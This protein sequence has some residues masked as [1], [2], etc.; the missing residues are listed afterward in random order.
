MPNFP[1]MQRIGHLG[2][3][4]TN[5]I[6]LYA[7]QIEDPLIIEVRTEITLGRRGGNGGIQPGVDL[8]AYGAYERGVS[9]VHAC[10]RRTEEGLVLTDEGSSNGTWVNGTLLPAHLSKLLTPG[11][12]F[13]L[14]RLRLEVYFVPSVDEPADL[15][16]T[17]G[18]YSTSS[19][20]ANFSEWIK[21]R[22]EHDG[23]ALNGARSE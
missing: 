22:S 1:V 17:I 3:L 2:K 5:S 14:G 13:W 7:N 16:E 9:R 21:N 12:Q 20:R 4:G 10:I 18:R 11:D 15:D 8:S 23:R 6:A 19:R